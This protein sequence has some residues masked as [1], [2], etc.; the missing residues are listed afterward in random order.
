MPRPPLAA[1]ELVDLEEHS[2]DATAFAEN[3]DHSK[4][5]LE[6]F[7]ERTAILVARSNGLESHRQIV[8]G[9][10]NNTQS[11]LAYALETNQT[12]KGT[13]TEQLGKLG[14]KNNVV[15]AELRN[16]L[17]EVVGKL[18]VIDLNAKTKRQDVNEPSM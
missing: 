4:V 17:Q 2:L 18:H 5:I 12:R 8:I 13:L 15:E 9:C 14:K 1:L 11:V 10:T 16:R 6:G 7:Q 3:F